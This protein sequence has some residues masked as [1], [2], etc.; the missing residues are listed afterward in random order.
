M[1]VSK[2]MQYLSRLIED[3]EIGIVVSLK[4]L[5]NLSEIIKRYDREKLRANVQKARQKL[6]MENHIERLIAFYE[7]VHSRAVSEKMI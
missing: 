4:D 6:S 2:E 7:E 5:D 1:I 3:Y